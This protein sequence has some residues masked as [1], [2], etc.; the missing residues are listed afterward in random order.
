MKRQDFSTSNSQAIYERASNVLAGGSTRLTTYFAPHPLYAVSGQ[1]STVVDADGV[2]RVDCLN[3]YMTLIH[4]HAHPKILEALYGAALESPATKRLC[5]CDTVG[6]SIP[7]AEE[8]GDITAGVKIHETG[9]VPI[10][11]GFTRQRRDHP[12]WREVRVL[13]VAAEVFAAGGDASNV[14]N[15]RTSG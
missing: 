4:G 14:I 8:V 2:S 11:S 9:D 15:R 13:A 7:Q 1:G 12:S 5:F 3:N 6:H 10:R